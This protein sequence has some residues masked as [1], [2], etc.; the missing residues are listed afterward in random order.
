MPVPRHWF[1]QA[2][3]TLYDLVAE[4]APTTGGCSSRTA[5]GCRTGALESAAVPDLVARDMPRPYERAL[6]ALADPPDTP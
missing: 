1:E 5:A 2:V 4:T 3:L 6:D